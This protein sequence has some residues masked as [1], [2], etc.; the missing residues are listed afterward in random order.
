MRFTLKTTSA[1]ALVLGL[2]AAPAHAD[3]DAAIAFLDEHI[4]R[5]ALTREE[6]EA[7]LQW[8]IE[9]GDNLEVGDGSRRVLGPGDVLL[10]EDTTGRGHKSRSVD[11]R[12]RSCLFITLD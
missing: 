8:F 10:A 9:A 7:E 2:T 1:L 5:S 3:M 4:E 6:Q 11:G 12:P